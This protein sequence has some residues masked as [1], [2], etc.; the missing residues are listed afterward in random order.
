MD[1]GI[2]QEYDPE[3]DALSEFPIYLRSAEAFH[4]EM[5]PYHELDIT[6]EKILDTIVSLLSDADKVDL[7][8]IFCN[9]YSIFRPLKFW[10][11]QEPYKLARYWR[12]NGGEPKILFNTFGCERNEYHI[13]FV[14]YLFHGKKFQKTGQ[15]PSV[16]DLQLPQIAKYR[17]LLRDEYRE[18][19]KAVRLFSNGVGAGSLVYL[20]RIFENLINEA[21]NEAIRPGTGFP[22]EKYNDSDMGEKV[23][24]LK[25]HLPGF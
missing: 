1:E 19:S 7:Y 22:I 14:H 23:K 8:C 20:R 9:D 18:F 6:D 25:D 5:P 10:N 12:E 15:Y 13:Y 4:F 2:L 3:K 16:A 21:K 11:H 24:L 17:S